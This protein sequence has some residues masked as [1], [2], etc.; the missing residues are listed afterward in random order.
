MKKGLFYSKIK[1]PLGQPVAYPGKPYHPTKLLPKTE[2]PIV[3]DIV[4]KCYC[5]MGLLEFI[6][7]Y[8]PTK[9]NYYKTEKTKG[10]L[11]NSPE[12][13][14]S[15]SEVEEKIQNIKEVEDLEIK[16]VPTD[17]TFEERNRQLQEVAYEVDNLRNSTG[18]RQLKDRSTTNKQLFEFIKKRGLHAVW[19]DKVRKNEWLSIALHGY[20]ARANTSK[21]QYNTRKYAE[22][23]YTVDTLKGLFTHHNVVVDGRWRKPTLFKEAWKNGWL[24]LDPNEVLNLENPLGLHE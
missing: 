8:D 6:K 13:K 3:L 5:K 17:I 9:K 7:E 2:D 12:D 10:I 16:E 18:L 20:T 24:E 15:E 11:E 4:F 21:H 19:D 22:K 1:N 23:W 14:L